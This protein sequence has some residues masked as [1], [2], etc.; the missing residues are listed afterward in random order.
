MG[1][2]WSKSITQGA[3][4]KQGKKVAAAADGDDDDEGEEKEAGE[5]FLQRFLSRRPSG[6]H[7]RKNAPT[8][9]DRLP[10]NLFKHVLEQL[11]S[12]SLVQM[13]CVCKKWNSF[14][15]SSEI[16][17]RFFRPKNVLFNFSAAELTLR[18]YSP[19]PTHWELE[20]KSL[21]FLLE[22]R[23]ADLAAGGIRAPT[24]LTS[25]WLRLV[26]AGGG[27][28]CFTSS[29]Y[30]WTFIVCN[31]LTKKWR[32]LQ[33]PFS[34]NT[35]QQQ[36]QQQQQ[37]DRDRFSV[38]IN[39]MPPPP[40]AVKLWN[41]KNRVMDWQAKLD[42]E[43]A[44]CLIVDSDQQQQGGQQGGRDSSNSYK[45]V[46]AGL[47][48]GSQRTTLV[49]HSKTTAWK[50]IAD[51]P[52]MQSKDSR[53]CS[54]AITCNGHM[55]C[56]TGEFQDRYAILRRP[57]RLLKCNMQT[58]TWS[59]VALP[60]ELGFPNDLVEHGGKILLLTHDRYNIGN[61]LSF[62]ELQ[63]FDS[64][65]ESSAVEM[66]FSPTTTSRLPKMLTEW[67]ND[68]RKQSTFHFSVRCLGM[69]NVMY[70]STKMDKDHKVLV[71]NASD[72]TCTTTKSPK[73][74]DYIYDAGWQVFSPALDAT[75]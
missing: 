18:V 4:G 11:P 2:C 33:M 17:P 12:S 36:T 74:A 42:E 38:D 15:L 39:C 71:F 56:L 1:G 20:R 49:Y 10:D 72:Q 8:S 67:L 44:V 27:L 43:L 48:E 47:Y 62:Y 64:S 35:Q 5:S 66:C 57:T 55:F 54:R 59:E 73:N 70:I 32:R 60:T 26:A 65:S 22:T 51:V 24:T 29:S 25:R 19:R 69:G 9:F 53:F 75:V 68:C 3:D 30:F 23:A 13:R 37:H 21:S 58:E 52:A 28:L 63:E 41:S 46:V 7:L 16:T 50:K 6:I 31:P 14:I 45:L 34:N 61:S 40:W